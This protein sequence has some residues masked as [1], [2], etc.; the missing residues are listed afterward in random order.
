[1]NIFLLFLGFLGIFFLFIIFYSFFY[2]FPLFPL[3][4]MHKE[5]LTPFNPENKSKV[6]PISLYDLEKE[7]EDIS[8]NV[9]NLKKQ[10]DQ[11]VISQA[12][13]LSKNQPAQPNISLSS[14]S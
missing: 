1:M 14:V 12:N 10:V 7:V 5:G 6:V 13:Y 4:P 9:V 11:L 8:G 2:Y 3:F